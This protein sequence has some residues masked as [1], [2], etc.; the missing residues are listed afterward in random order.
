MTKLKSLIIA[1]QHI[2]EVRRAAMAL[3]IEN[4]KYYI[5]QIARIQS[6]IDYEV[7]KKRAC[8]NVPE[9]NYVNQKTKV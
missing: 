4:D 5:E 1:R 8:E 7:S 3:A 9:G 6:A 2:K